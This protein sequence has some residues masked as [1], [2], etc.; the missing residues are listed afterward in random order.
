MWRQRARGER[1]L[2]G[3][4][5][6]KA[7]QRGCRAGDPAN[8][9]GRRNRA[10]PGGTLPLTRRSRAGVNMVHRMANAGTGYLTVTDHGRCDRRV[11]TLRRA[12]GSGRDRPPST[13]GYADTVQQPSRPRSGR[14]GRQRPSERAAAGPF[15]KS[16]GASL[17]RRLW[18]ARSVPSEIAM[19]ALAVNSR[20]ADQ[21]IVAVPATEDRAEADFPARDFGRSRPGRPLR[22]WPP[23]AALRTSE[24]PK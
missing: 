13:V 22:E 8:R 14:P 17:P 4:G 9:V 24:K 23:A 21:L 19:L 3:I 2:D 1:L 10:P 12:V 16:D 11:T 15:W 7:P 6:A 18:S 5:S 20:R